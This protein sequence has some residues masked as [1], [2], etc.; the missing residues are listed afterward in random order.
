MEDI[1]YPKQVLDYR[2]IE[3]LNGHLK[4]LLDGYSHEDENRSFIG[5]TLRLGVGGGEE[6]RYC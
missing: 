2:P 3:D 5:L 4:T 1:T 6:Y